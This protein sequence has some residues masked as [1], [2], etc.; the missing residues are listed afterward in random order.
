MPLIS[1]GS[2][3]CRVFWGGLIPRQPPTCQT[4]F[5]NP[6]FNHVNTKCQRDAAIMELFPKQKLAVS[7]ELFV[8]CIHHCRVADVS[9]LLS[10]GAV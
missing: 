9:I 8:D 3:N 5:Y 1:V 2:P 7:K 10:N 6:T 4:C